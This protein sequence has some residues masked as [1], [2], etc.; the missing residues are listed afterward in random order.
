MGEIHR[1]SSVHG[2]LAEGSKRSVGNYI[3]QCRKCKHC[4]LVEIVRTE[5]GDES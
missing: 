2:Q 1:Q 5:T 4:G 3:E